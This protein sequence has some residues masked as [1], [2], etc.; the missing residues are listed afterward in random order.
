MRKFS[1]L[2]RVLFS[3]EINANIFVVVY[4]LLTFIS[5]LLVKHNNVENPLWGYSVGAVFTIINTYLIDFVDRKHKS[6]ESCDHEFVIYLHIENLNKI[7][8]ANYCK[9]CYKT[10]Y[11]RIN[12]IK[13]VTSDLLNK[14]TRDYIKSKIL[15]RVK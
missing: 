10:L 5:E 2:K 14:M 8:D 3:L 15:K 4:I 7:V 6:K 13:L 9:K 12:R 1:F 11:G